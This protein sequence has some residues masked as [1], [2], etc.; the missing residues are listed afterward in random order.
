[1]D[2]YGWKIKEFK[3]NKNNIE[4]KRKEMLEWC[5]KWKHK[6]VFRNIFIDN[7]WAVEY[8]LLLHF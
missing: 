2:S 6:Y 1:M 7:A 3:F 8:K 5:N 4:G